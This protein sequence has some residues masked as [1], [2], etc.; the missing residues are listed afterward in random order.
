MPNKLDIED[1]SK[2]ESDI[3]G[4]RKIRLGELLDI[5]KQEVKNQLEKSKKRID[6]RISNQESGNKTNSEKGFYVR[7]KSESYQV[8][9]LIDEDDDRNA[10]YMHFRFLHYPSS[11]HGESISW[12]IRPLQAKPSQVKRMAKMLLE[13]MI[14]SLDLYELGT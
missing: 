6:F 12:S 1:E 10:K 3:A 8:A 5:A 11:E 14:G 4:F 9:I 7:P 2:G 13:M